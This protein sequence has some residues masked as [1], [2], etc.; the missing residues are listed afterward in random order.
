MKFTPTR[1]KHILLITLSVIS[2]VVCAQV[3]FKKGDEFQRQVLTKS[4]CVLQRGS[5]TLHV[6]SFSIVTKTY[7]VTEVSDKGATIIITT[8]KIID[9]INAMDQNL[10]YNSDKAADPNSAIQVGLQKTLNARSAVMV[11]NKGEILSVRNTVAV[12]DTLLSFAGI[13]PEYLS[14][15]AMLQFMADFPLNPSVKKGYSWTDATPLKETNYTIYAIT[16]H[17]TTITHKTSIL[18]GNMNS[19]I[20]G[21]LLIDNFTGL[22]LKRYA[23]SVSTGYEMV[24]GIVYTATRRT[25]TTEV[26]VKK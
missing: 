14:P 21:S 5:Q 7:R 20:N 9:T 6:S 13:Q 12:N 26:T 17:T 1:V 16:G 25:A 8:D 4:N 2:G 10:V 19:R 3:R 15:G 18:G 11:N 23:Q 22:I 24:N